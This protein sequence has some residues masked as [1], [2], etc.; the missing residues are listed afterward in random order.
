V[1]LHRFLK[2]LG[3]GVPELYYDGSKRGFLLLEDIGDTALRDAAQE[4]SPSEVE[5][6][7]RL[8]IDELL[9]LQ[10]E[11]TRRPDPAC[12]AFR[13]RFDERLFRWEFEHFIEF[14]LERR[15]GVP[16]APAEAKELRAV[17][18]DIA[19]RLDEQP[20]YLN[21]RDYHSWN[22]FWH[23]GRIRVIDFQDALL[24]PAPYDL[25]TLL[26]DRDTP[27]VV[28]ASLERALVEYY[29]AGWQRRTGSLPGGDD[30][31]EVYNLALLQKAHKVVGRFYYLELVKGKRG[32]RRYIPPTLATIGR[33]LE[34]LPR[35]ERLRA[36]LAEHFVELRR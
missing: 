22:L 23:G 8:A 6:L 15:E 13:Q 9:L 35:Y 4:A 21:H 24:A 5:R 7:Y 18:T 26:N 36:I 33:A 25:A 32:Y 30:V 19:R 1:N 2:R 12:L 16:L 20:S 27:D 14:G 10:T 3:L 31:W 34:R 17:F 28:G 29:R 11:G